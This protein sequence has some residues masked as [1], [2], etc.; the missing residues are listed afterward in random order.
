MNTLNDRGYAGDVKTRQLFL[1]CKRWLFVAPMTFFLTS[2]IYGAIIHQA[3]NPTNGHTY[4]LVDLAAD[5]G[6]RTNTWVNL[7]AEAVNIGGHLVTVN[8]ADE[9]LWIDNTFPDLLP[10]GSNFSGS[11]STTLRLR[12]RGSG[13]EERE[14]PGSKGRQIQIPTRIGGLVNPMMLVLRERILE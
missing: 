7:E 10:S 12:V 5:L 1:D 8:D 6:G 3:V 9:E 11:V 4:L 14:S 2:P 13:P